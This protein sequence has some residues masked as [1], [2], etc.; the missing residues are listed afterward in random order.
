MEE[1]FVVLN[2]MLISKDKESRN[3][4]AA[5]V[6]ANMESLAN[7]AVSQYALKVSETLELGAL[8]NL[9]WKSTKY[10]NAIIECWAKGKRNGTL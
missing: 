4:A 9:M 10:H 2:Q 8:R 3:L 1:E 5:I 6:E 7:S